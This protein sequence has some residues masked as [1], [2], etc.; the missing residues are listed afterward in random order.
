MKE[1]GVRGAG[2]R[3]C[4]PLEKCDVSTIILES[5][6]DFNYDDAEGFS[7]SKNM[8][9]HSNASLDLFH[10]AL[11]WSRRSLSFIIVNGF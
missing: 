2:V 7:G 8:L 5:K 6:L 11:S 3:V 10:H 4:A 1:R 9:T